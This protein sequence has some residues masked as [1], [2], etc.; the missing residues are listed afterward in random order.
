MRGEVVYLDSSAFIKL[1]LSEL[2]SPAL[3]RYLEARPYQV[4]AMLLRTEVL[5]AA[6]R[7][8]LSAQQMNS[9]RELLD[10]VDLIQADTTLS[11]EAGV[12]NP[13]DLR[14]LDAIHLATARSLGSQLGAL[15]TYDR[16]LAVAAAWYGLPVVSP[17]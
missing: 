15:A 1:F 11:D 17:S 14:S 9:V 2:D 7:T 5:R 4:S 13:S 10:R 6:V 3:I 12:L 16:R 8:S